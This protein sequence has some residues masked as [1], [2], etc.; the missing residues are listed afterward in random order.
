[1][2]QDIKLRR[3]RKDVKF[4]AKSKFCIHE[5]LIRSEIG[6]PGT[7]I[8]CMYIKYVFCETFG[9][10]GAQEAELYPKEAY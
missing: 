6:F 7:I 1:M 4:P 8:L 10:L 5:T 2:Y 3:K 9:P